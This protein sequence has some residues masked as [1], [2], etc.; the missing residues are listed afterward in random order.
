LMQNDAHIRIG[1]PREQALKLM[2]F[3]IQYTKPS[4]Y[5]SALPIAV[6]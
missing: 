6:A 4:V 3:G 1:C 2:N 5:S